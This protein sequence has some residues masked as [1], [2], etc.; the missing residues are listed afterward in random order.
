MRFSRRNCIGAGCWPMREGRE[1]AGEMGE[2]FKCEWVSLA[3][4]PGVAHRL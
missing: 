2:L 1:M 3:D 4:A